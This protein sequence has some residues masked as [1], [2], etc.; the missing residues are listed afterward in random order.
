M[1][2]ARLDDRAVR[3]MLA[4]LKEKDIPKVQARALNRALSTVITRSRRQIATDMDMPQK[5]IRRR[6]FKKQ[7]RRARP[8]R[9]A[10]SFV[11][12]TL[13]IPVRFY[14][15]AKRN[16]ATGAKVG[17]RYFEGGFVRAPKGTPL[18]FQRKTQRRLPIE[19]VKVAFDPA[20]VVY[21]VIRRDGAEVFVKRIKHEL[22]RI[23][24]V[25]A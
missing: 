3:R 22:E 18:V 4:K 14:K 13:D 12:G 24:G 25:K 15:G 9:L 2:S 1:I 17:A 19:Q 11:V 6:Y 7:Q 10:A 21:T 8:K 5:A 16:V 20:P 23:T